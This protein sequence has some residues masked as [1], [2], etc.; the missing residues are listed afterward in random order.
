[1][2]KLFF[3]LFA[4]LLI[5]SKPPEKPLSYDPTAVTIDDPEPPYD[6]TQPYPPPPIPPTIPPGGPSGPCLND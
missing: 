3:S 6:P 2:F 1:M 5:T 4:V